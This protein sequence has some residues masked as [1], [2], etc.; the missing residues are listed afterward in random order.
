MTVNVVCGK[1]VYGVLTVRVQV[2]CSMLR[3]LMRLLIT[4]VCVGLPVVMK[5]VLYV[6]TAVSYG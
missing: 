1:K 3:W 4:V 5:L 6:V 2:L